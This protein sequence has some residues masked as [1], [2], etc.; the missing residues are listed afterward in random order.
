MYAKFC[1]STFNAIEF[2]REILFKMFADSNIW[3]FS[4]VLSA[5]YILPFSS[6]AKVSFWISENE[7]KIKVWLDKM[8]KGLE[9][10][11]GLSPC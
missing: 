1:N 3:F 4:Y 10:G 7:L 6:I 11:L 2:F 8:G 5:N 9:N